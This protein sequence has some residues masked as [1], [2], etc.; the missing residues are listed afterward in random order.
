MPCS[1]TYSTSMSSGE[2][3]TSLLSI[4][5]LS[6]LS[7]PAQGLTVDW[8]W[9]VGGVERKQHDFCVVIVCTLFG[10]CFLVL[11][12]YIVVFLLFQHI[13][14]ALGIIEDILLAVDSLVLL[15]FDMATTC[16]FC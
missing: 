8:F 3:V 6:G 12:S 2:I 11:H 7:V 5:V 4:L 16:L 13:V 14:S 9:V 15:G 10:F 1:Q